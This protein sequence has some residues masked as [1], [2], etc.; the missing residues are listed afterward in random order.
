MVAGERNPAALAQLRHARVQASEEVVVKSLVRDYR[1]EHLFPLGQSLEAYRYYQTLIPT[2][3][4]EIEEQLQNFDSQLPSD[5]PQLPPERYPH[6][7]R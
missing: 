5:A 4:Q 6:R 3:D 7:P 1:R 2:C